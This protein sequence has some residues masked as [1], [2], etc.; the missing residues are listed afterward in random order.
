VPHGPGERTAI[1]FTGGGAVEPSLVADL[2]ADALV[3]A[4][5]S[6]LDLARRFGVP[7]DVAVGDF[8][9]VSGEA[10][11]EAEA[12]G[13]TIVR[14]PVAKDTTDLELALEEARRAGAARIIVVGGAE[15]R[16][17]HLLGNAL[18]LGSEQWVDLEIDA[19]FG[20]ASVHVVRDERRLEGAPAELVTLLAAHGPAEGVHTQ[21]LLYPLAGETL[22]PG[23]TRGL[24]NQLVGS[25]AVVTVRAG[26]LLVVRPGES[27]PPLP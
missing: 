10:L 27:G 2:P 19:R 26:T 3:V 11:A 17:D 8:D 15:G 12:A 4:A 22:V 1:V 13:T 21:G 24:S 20:R 18:V 5:D 6:G 25:S 16:F 9:S 7:V 14:H 23:S